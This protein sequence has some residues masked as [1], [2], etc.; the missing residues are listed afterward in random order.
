MTNSIPYPNARLRRLRRSK[1]LRDML[2]NPMPGPEKFVYPMFVTEGMGVK[3]EISAMPGQHRWSVDRL[4]EVIDVLQAQGINSVLLF[5]VPGA[6]AKSADA[7]AAYHPEG[8]VPR[9]IRRLRSKF[10]QLQIMTDVCLCA[11]TDDGHCELPANSAA[12]RNDRALDALA[13]IAVIHAQAGADTLA[14]SAMMD[15][16]VAAIR[17]A[18]D[19]AEF[20]DR[21]IMSYSTKFASSMYGPFRDAAASAPGKGDRRGYQAD[22]RDPRTALRESYQDAR[23]GADILMVKPSLFYLDLIC[24][25]R[26]TTQLPLAAYNVSGEY[27]MLAASAEKGYGDLKAMVGESIHALGRAGVDIIISY[28]ALRYDEL[29]GGSES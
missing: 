14:P 16:Q 6:H 22:F 1:T 15:G 24:E 2:A 11:Y 27:G 28:W 10:P 25:L 5:G 29:M 21:A 17:R 13:K 20:A 19:D 4:P 12:E 23:E 9:A 18:L 8:N 3:E 7:A 26:R